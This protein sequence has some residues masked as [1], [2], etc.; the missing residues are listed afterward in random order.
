MC[1]SR[2]GYGECPSFP[3]LRAES[4]EPPQESKRSLIAGTVGSV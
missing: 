1:H 4:A 3:I 2:Y